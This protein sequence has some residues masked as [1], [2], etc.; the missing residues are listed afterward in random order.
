K[1]R[2]LFVAVEGLVVVELVELL[3]VVVGHLLLVEFVVIE[4]V[5]ELLLIFVF[6]VLF[7]VGWA[8]LDKLVPG[9]RPELHVRA[10]PGGLLGGI[11]TNIPGVKTES[12]ERRARRPWGKIRSGRRPDA[13][14]R[15]CSSAAEQGSHKPRVGGS[16]PPTATNNSITCEAGF[17]ERV[18]WPVIVIVTR[19]GTPRRI[20][21]L[22]AVLLKSWRSFPGTPAS[23]PCSPCP[24]KSY[25]L[26]SNTRW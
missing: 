21:F 17:P 23:L 10:P 4:V 2:L 25:R 22:A 14:A 18:R 1:I 13:S 24:V 3:R 5:V 19:S 11:I 9:V 7:V 16:I 15:R 6:V 8:A 12:G 20:R 26:R